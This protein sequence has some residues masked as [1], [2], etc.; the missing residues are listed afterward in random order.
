MALDDWQEQ[1]A[2]H[3]SDLRRN[4]DFESRGRPI[5]ALE[6][7]LTSSEITKLSDD[8]RQQIQV[9][10]PSWNHRLVWAVFAAEFGYLYSGDEYWQTFEAQTPG[11]A[12]RGNRY[13]LRSCFLDFHKQYG[14]ARPSGT[15]ADHFSIICWPITHAILP[16]DLQRQLAKVL[17]E[18]R[19][20]LLPGVVESPERIGG[21]IASR[22]WNTT[23]RFQQFSEEPLLLAQIAS[24]LLLHGRRSTSAL[25][26][27]PTLMRISGDVEKERSSRMWLKTARQVANS[28]INFPAIQPRGSVDPSQGD[29]P[30]NRSREFCQPWLEPKLSLCPKGPREWQVRLE[31]PDIFQIPP[32]LQPYA[33]LLRGS[34]CFVTG[35]SGRPRVLYGPQS[36]SL[37]Q[38]PSV[39]QPLLRFEK[40]TPEFDS[41]LASECVLPEKA[42]WLFKVAA[43]GIAYEVKRVSVRAGQKYVVLVNPNRSVRQNTCIT[44]VPVD[45]SGIAAFE[46]A[47]PIAIT[48]D[49]SS[50]LA[51]LGIGQ[52]TTL[53]IWPAGLV[54]AFW[55]GEG[56][57]EW[58]T[59]ER[60]RIGISADHHVE[61][62]TVSLGSNS[63]QSVPE[64]D[65]LPVF[66][67]LPSLMPGSYSV[68]IS[69]D[70]G[71]QSAIERAS[72]LVRMRNPR[73][74]SPGIGNSGTF[75]VT[76]DPHTIS[77]EDLWSGKYDI[78]L[79]GPT[80]RKIQ[81]DLAFFRKGEAKPFLHKSGAAVTL[82]ITSGQWMTFFDQHF[83][84]PI[85]AQ[86]AFDIAYSCRL[87][88]SAGELGAFHCNAEREFT[89]L[90]WALKRTRDGM[91]LTILDD[92]GESG[93]L[94]ILRY[95]F[96]TPDVAEQL[97]A[98]AFGQVGGGTAGPGLYFAQNAVN[99]C[100]VISPPVIHGFGDLDITPNLLHRPRSVESILD[101]VRVLDAW[102]SA[103]LTGN[104]FS[105][106]IRRRMLLGISAEL[107][108]LIA[109]D[110]WAEA[111]AAFFNSGGKPVLSCVGAYYR[112]REEIELAECI[113]KC[114][115]ELAVRS[116]KERARQ[117]ASMAAGT[118]YIDIPRSKMPVEQWNSDTRLIWVTELALRLS[119][120]SPGTQR[121]AESNLK[122]GVALLL[123]YPS[124]VR[125]SRVMVFVLEQFSGPISAE[126]SLYSGWRW[127]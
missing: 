42:C 15:W 63:I 103:N 71:G 47:L 115:S 118:L 61:R 89:P 114:A 18:L 97:D 87:R 5:F 32:E 84:R 127:N 91:L 102:S 16:R 43:D 85:D 34:R 83:K 79:Y 20:S 80:G 101:L 105:G 23:S 60:P 14:G 39:Q 31:L 12:Q 73:Q 25:I 4:R 52:S 21:L 111:E 33:E 10:S 121:W 112:K 70:S 50:T 126:T 108:R 75:F 59:N 107:V 117:L 125:A 69:A 68:E 88:I 74:W 35:S 95:A 64:A 122:P 98:S 2:T 38:W 9:G 45:C 1:L 22:S 65:G 40:S 116:P 48:Q 72:L 109:G 3:F 93:S 100:S 82:P 41:L 94:E 67:E 27:S 56:T 110:N 106:H 46:L 7:G 37:K 29:F 11:W 62:I 81:C 26:H 123:E 8:I 49:L 19:Y 36:I 77:F 120:A 30:A 124:L 76:L 57:A 17:Y 66:V 51:E 90:R 104:V 54:P 99:S 96:E 44:A 24:A 119:A 58:L 92:G 78:G 53:R 55:D 86:N 6:H 28:Q 113:R 13:W